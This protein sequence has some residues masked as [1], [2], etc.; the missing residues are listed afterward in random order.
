M[1]KQRIQNKKPTNKQ[2]DRGEGGYRG[3]GKRGREEIYRFNGTLIKIPAGS[4]VKIDI[5][6]LKLK[7]K[8]KGHRIAKIILKKEQS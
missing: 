2:K 6:I 3:G 7:W 1:Q 5:D 8:Y 4:F